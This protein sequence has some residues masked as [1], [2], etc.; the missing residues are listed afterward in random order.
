[1]SHLQGTSHSLSWDPFLR[2][3]LRLQCRVLK[4]LRWVVGG[5]SRTQFTLDMRLRSWDLG[6]I[7]DFCRTLVIMT[8]TGHLNEGQKSSPAEG[9]P[10]WLVVCCRT[11]GV[12]VVLRAQSGR[13]GQGRSAPADQGQSCPGPVPP[14]AWVGDSPPGATRQH[15]QASACWALRL[16]RQEGSKS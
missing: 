11:R 14:W 12:A 2:A 15:S 3:G 10:R 9:S 7:L 16:T 4:S 1:M 8:P 6:Q 5:S 13:A